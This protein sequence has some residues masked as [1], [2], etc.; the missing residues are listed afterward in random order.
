MSGI[1]VV[2]VDGRLDDALRTLKEKFMNSGASKCNATSLT[3]R[4][5]NGDGATRGQR[6]HVV[7]R[8]PGEAAPVVNRVGR[9][10]PVGVRHS[11]SGPLYLTEDTYRECRNARPDFHWD[12][13]E[14]TPD[15]QMRRRVDG[16]AIVMIIENTPA[17]DAI[18]E[19]MMATE[20][21]DV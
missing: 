13:W 5:P 11:A 6:G 1:T 8:L 15:I 14:G 12:G 3:Q 16:R 21:G 20:P 7:A 18:R 4:P 17:A 9:E 10:S 2:V 19:A